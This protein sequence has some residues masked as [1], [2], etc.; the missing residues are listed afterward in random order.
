MIKGQP[1]DARRTLPPNFVISHSQVAPEDRLDFLM[2]IVRIM[3]TNNFASRT[4]F[5]KAKPMCN[6]CMW[7]AALRRVVTHVAVTLPPQVQTRKA[8]IQVMMLKVA[9]FILD[10]G[11]STHPPKVVHAA[12]ITLERAPTYTTK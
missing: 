6:L 11:G 10:A 5:L 9:E 1:F 3:F 12:T 2:Q 4:L 7:V 8:T